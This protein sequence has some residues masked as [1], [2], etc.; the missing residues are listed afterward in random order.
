MSKSTPPEELVS[1]VPG[2]IPLEELIGI[3]TRLGDRRFAEEQGEAFFLLH[4]L[5]LTRPQLLQDTVADLGTAENQGHGEKGFLAV[6]IRKGANNG[7]PHITL[8]RTLNNDVVIT[9][10]TVSKF[11]AYLVQTDQNY[12][13]QDAGSKN[14]CFVNDEA[15][16]E[17]AAGKPI[18]LNRKATL[19]VGSVPLTFVRIPDLHEFA[20]F[21][22]P[23]F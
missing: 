8:G 9:D 16:L 7:F 14:G 5:D 13:V 20:K 4:Q 6:P 3:L 21:F 19:R 22:V 18:T 15:V 1:D 17:K 2:A 12:A 10:V 23:S 11:H